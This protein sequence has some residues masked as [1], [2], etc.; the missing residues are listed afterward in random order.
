MF[1]KFVQKKFVRTFRSLFGAR[2][3]DRLG[4]GSGRFLLNMCEKGK[5]VGRV[6]DGVGTGKETG[7]SM[8]ERFSK[9]PLALV[10]PSTG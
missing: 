1:E 9:I 3:L 8:C 5:G 6:G 7:K 10:A 4:S 2:G